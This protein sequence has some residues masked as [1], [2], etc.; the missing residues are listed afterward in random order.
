MKVK[1][2]KYLKGINENR[3]IDI[4]IDNYDTWSLDNTLAMI[5]L[6]ALIQLKLTKH[7][8]P[9][10]F[11][12]NV[13]GDLDRNYVFDFIYDDEKRVF[14]E[15]CNKWNET[16]DKM[17]WSFQQIVDG[18]YDSKYHHGKMEIGFKESSYTYTNPITGKTEKAFEMVDKNPDGH[19]VDY[20]GLE[21]H[22]KRI[23]E[24]LEL[25]G[26]HMRD[27]WD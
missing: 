11:V 20:I 16:M 27:L 7:G 21:L 6:P 8:V 14:E 24:G 2:G 19:W 17:I 23:Q 18:Q 10:E 1:I 22:E 12:N 25:F 9:G 3:K 13:G 15:S 5:I 4:Q 26:K